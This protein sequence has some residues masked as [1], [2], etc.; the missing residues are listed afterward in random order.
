M[1]TAADPDADFEREKWRAEMA[2]R[3]RELALKER[4]GSL[5]KSP[6]VV[7][8]IAVFV[9]L[10]SNAVSDW[11]TKDRRLA[12]E[13]RQREA[14]LLVK[15]FEHNDPNVVMAKLNLLNLTGMISDTNELARKLAGQDYTEIES[16]IKSL[17]SESLRQYQA[18]LIQKAME[19]D[20]VDKV[21]RKLKLLDEA[22]LIPDYDKVRRAYATLGTVAGLPMTAS[23]ASASTT[24]VPIATASS[25]ST[26]TA[27]TSAAAASSPTTTSAAPCAAATKS[28]E[29]WIFLGGIDVSLKKWVVSDSGTRSIDFET[30]ELN[31]GSSFKVEEPLTKV[32]MNQC[33]RTKTAKFLRGD[34]IDGRRLQSAIKHTL[35]S[36]TR[37]RVVAIDAVG[38]DDASSARNPVLWAR[39]EVLS[40]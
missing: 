19:N 15:A 8:A 30:P 28:M 27:A 6:I 18:A 14:A 22:S 10:L 2:L 1:P 21:L 16:K 32:V 33:L 26:A 35:P 40:D 12:E 31:A 13:T 29:G 37:L 5:F 23:T 24:A 11:I 36:G 7:S 9:G 38:R 4:E 17:P 34:G 25:T 3:E 20:D 39:V